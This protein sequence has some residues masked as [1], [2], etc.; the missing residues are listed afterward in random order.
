M[1]DTKLGIWSV[2]NTWLH[3]GSRI[4]ERGPFYAVYMAIKIVFFLPF[5]FALSKIVI[6]R[7][8]FSFQGKKFLYERSWYNMTWRSERTVEIPIFRNLMENY[9]TDDILEVGNVMR[10]YNNTRHAVVDKYEVGN[11]ITNEDILDFETDK[12]YR[13]VFS[14]STLEHIGQDE[15]HGVPEKAIEAIKRIRNL[16][17]QGGEFWFSVPLG[18]NKT[19]DSYCYDNLDAFKKVIYMKRI[20]RANRWVEEECLSLENVRYGHPYPFAN[21]I[22]IGV[23]DSATALGPLQVTKKDI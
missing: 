21:V 9:N 20:A 4:R 14:I 10:H 18:H 13:F 16:L 1:L 22:F 8:G 15:E 3:V 12:R 11:E 6:P 19:L 7:S 5:S 23:I 2:K 17:C